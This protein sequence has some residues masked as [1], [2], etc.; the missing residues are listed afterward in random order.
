MR[1]RAVIFDFDG[2]ILDTET[3]E[4][5]AW[6]PEYDR[7]GWPFPLDYFQWA[8]GR[9]AEQIV[10]TPFERY[11]SVARTSGSTATLDYEEVTN[12]VRDRRA[13]ALRELEPRP[14]IRELIDQAGIFGTVAIASSSDGGWVTGHL[15]RVGLRAAFEVVVTRERVERTKPAPDLY[16]S[17]LSDLDVEPDE[18]IVLE[19]SRNGV[20]AA[21]AAGIAV[22]AFP[23]PLTAGLDFSEATTVWTQERAPSYSELLAIHAASRR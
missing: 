4:I 22:V 11:V 18:A 12:R 21:Q 20:L 3:T 23:N 6:R 17:A 15:D 1:L 5:E 19:D 8:V 16:L 10:E 13:R 9:G 14:G 2:L 7:F